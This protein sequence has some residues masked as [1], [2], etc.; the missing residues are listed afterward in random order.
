MKK[1]QKFC[2]FDS[3]ILMK[4]ETQEQLDYVQ[5]LV[6]L[7]NHSTLLGYLLNLI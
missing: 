6:I 4:Q 7:R 2:P 1:M 3:V 5:H